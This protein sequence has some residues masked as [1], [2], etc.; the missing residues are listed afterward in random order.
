MT[1]APRAAAMG[2]H[3]RD[4]PPPAEKSAM[5]TPSKTSGAM[6][7]TVYSSPRK[8]SFFPADRGEATTLNWVRGKSR[9]SNTRSIC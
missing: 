7:L 3:S 2:A 1:T 5:S 6:A 8:V 9:S 4:V